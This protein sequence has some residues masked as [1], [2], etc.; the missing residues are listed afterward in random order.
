MAKGKGRTTR[1]L[2]TGDLIKPFEGFDSGGFY[3]TP[4]WKATSRA[5]L[6]RDPV[7][8]WC[9]AVGVVRES[10]CADHIVSRNR[11]ASKGINPYDQ[12]NIVGS[13][14]SCNSKRASYEA[15]GYHMNTYQDWA[16]FLKNKR[17]GEQK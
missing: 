13:C 7:C 17:Y 9:L 1:N 15:K 2:E 16:T 12:T 4:Q 5:V 6:N 10:Q 3:G 14:R 11:C 8:Q